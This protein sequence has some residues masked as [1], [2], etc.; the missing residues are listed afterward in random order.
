MK[1][2]LFKTA[3]NY[4]IN[5]SEESLQKLEEFYHLLI[6]WNKNVNLTAITEYKDVALKHFVDSLTGARFIPENAT[7][8][9]IG[10]GAGFPGIPLKIFR[11]DI[12]IVLMDGL[13]KRVEF[14]NEAIEKLELK[15]IEAKHIRAE[16]A[17]EGDYR[18]QFNIAVARAVAR[19]NVLCEYALPLVKQGGTFIAYKTQNEEELLEAKRAIAMLGGR[20]EK[21]DSF[22]LDDLSRQLVVIRKI[23]PTPNKYPRANGKIK[24]N[25]L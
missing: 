19:L 6:E 2:Y 3:N 23:A 22:K 5:L 17:A 21:A 12:K 9:D 18:E 11:P 8:A 4:G 16:D 24:K 15:G 25:P 20:L 14:L 10:S 7:V 13:N 1:E